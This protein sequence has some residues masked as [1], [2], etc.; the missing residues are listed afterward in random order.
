[1]GRDRSQIPYHAGPR[2]DHEKIVREIDLPPIKSLPS[3]GRIV[4]V[5]IMPTFAESD[6]R[7][8]ETIPAPILSII[9]LGSYLMGEG[10]NCV[11]PVV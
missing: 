5:I 4:V 7:E 11:G 10:V 6:N 1:M 2:Q 3:R 8:R 9:A